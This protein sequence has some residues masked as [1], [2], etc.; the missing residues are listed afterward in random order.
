MNVTTASQLA[1]QLGPRH[2]VAIVAVD[3][4]LKYLAQE[5]FAA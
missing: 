2:T 1:R 5:L 4:G 3:F